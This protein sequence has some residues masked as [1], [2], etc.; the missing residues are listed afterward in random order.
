[1]YRLTATAGTI[2]HVASG[3][4]FPASDGGN[5]MSREYQEWLSENNAPEPLPTPAVVRVPCTPVYCQREI[6]TDAELT[7]L[8]TL[9]L[10]SVT[11]LK[12]LN[13]FNAASVVMPT[14]PGLA[15][16]LAF[17][18]Q[19]GLFTQQRVDEIIAAIAA[20]MP[21]DWGT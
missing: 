15:T 12:W 7:V 16:G 14:D 18:Q 2:M 10:N 9:S 19:A 20:G 5:A 11:A 4:T 17:M 8:T 1:M 6:L 13:Q 3:A 21:V